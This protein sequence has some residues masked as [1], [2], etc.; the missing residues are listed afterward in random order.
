MLT[1]PFR[2]PEFVAVI[3]EFAVDQDRVERPAVACGENMRAVDVGAGARAQ[4]PRRSTRAADGPAP[5]P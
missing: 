1:D 4:P 2:P 3:V 5:A